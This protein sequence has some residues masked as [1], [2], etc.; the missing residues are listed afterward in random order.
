MLTTVLILL[1]IVAGKS[2]IIYADGE[3]VEYFDLS[4]QD[5]WTSGE[6]TS[7]K[8]IHLYKIVL[9]KPGMLTVTIKNM[10]GGQIF[11]LVDEDL[12]SVGDSN[13]QI[14]SGTS[15]GIWGA[16]EVSPYVNSRSWY[17]EKG[18]YYVKIY[19]YNYGDYY[20]KYQVK[21]AFYDGQNM[22][23]E[24]N[25]NASQAMRIAYGQ[26]YKALISEQDWY[27]WYQFDVSGTETISILFRH[28]S[29]GSDW[30]LLKSD[31]TSVASGTCWGGTLDSPKTEYIT[32]TLAPGTYYFR[33]EYKSDSGFTHG[34][35]G[36]YDLMVF[37]PVTNITLN[38]QSPMYVGERQT[39]TAQIT[40]SNAT[41]QELGWSTSNNTIAEVSN[42]GIV[43]AKGVGTVTITAETIKGEK[44]SGSVKITVVDKPKNQDSDSTSNPDPDQKQDPAPTSDSTLGNLTTL[45]GKTEGLKERDDLKGSIFH[46]LQLKAKKIGKTFI[47][48]GWKKVPGATGYA[49]YGAGCGSRFVKLGDVMGNAFTHTGLK[50]GTYYWYFVAA[51][52]ANGKILAISKIA[53]IATSGGKK[54][55]TKSVGLNKKTVTLKKKQTFQLRAKLNNGKQKVSIHRKIAYE[56]DKPKVA[57][58]SKSG[59]IKAI[60]KGTCTIYVYAQNGV[61]AKCKVKVK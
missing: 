37:R 60:G 61:F 39:V 56:T 52:D 44:K 10:K 21:A 54:G 42:T 40:P 50:K 8:N 28:Y 18:T 43:T 7:N 59:K 27:D 11:F 53:H 31:L 38:C 17:L 49:V 32:K 57:T 4:L 36:F 46:I 35:R 19:P 5:A 33:N 34:V 12:R 29:S 2:Q 22:E 58:V 9:N 6:T 24:P 45:D 30:K 55:N 14:T 51:H 48:L 13:G 3:V 47:K 26:E 25:Q 15:G 20:G 23:T 16:T 1:G 41:F